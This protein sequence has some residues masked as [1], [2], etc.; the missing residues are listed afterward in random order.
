MLD[1]KANTDDINKVVVD[2]CKELDQKALAADLRHALKEQALINAGL[3]ADMS[4]GRWLWKSGKTK[5]GRTVPWNVQTINSDPDNYAWDKDKV[6]TQLSLK[7]HHGLF[8][9]CI[10][11]MLTNR[12][13]TQMNAGIYSNHCSRPVR[14]Q[15]WNLLEETAI[16][17]SLSERRPCTICYEQLLVCYQQFICSH[18][19]CQQSPSWQHH[20]IQLHGVSIP[21]SK[22]SRRHHLLWRGEV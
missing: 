4:F 15:L 19:Q 20:R 6:W 8:D 12:S 17:P 22:S 1:T 10:T 13:N 3:C 2:V 7:Q 16:C 9:D 21:S 11:R 5:A 18:E 14:N